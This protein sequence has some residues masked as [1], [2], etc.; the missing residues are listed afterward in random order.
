MK[1]HK[2]S[3]YWDLIENPRGEIYKNLVKVLC[4]HSDKFY[5]ITRKELEYNQ[6]IITQFA[7]Y[8]I[9][10]YKTKKWAG[11]ETKGPAA[12]VY[13][14]ESNEAT[15]DLL[16]QNASSLYDWVAPELP[17]DLT[18]IKNNFTWFTCTSHEEYASF[19]IRS[20]YYKKL[21]LKINGLKLERGE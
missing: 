16:V 12:T 17:E 4:H 10:T 7:P 8:C 5:F 21:I 13:I 19:S 9:E 14:M 18:F 1:W 15:Y 20:N 2:E 6:D 11:T 3:E